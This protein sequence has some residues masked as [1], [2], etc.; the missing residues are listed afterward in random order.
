MKSSPEL[1]TPPMPTLTQLTS[2]EKSIETTYPA[3]PL[4]SGIFFHN[5]FARASRAHIVQLTLEADGEFDVTAFRESLAQVAR[6]HEALRT[7]FVHLANKGLRQIVHR[8]KTP[9]L[10][11]TDL[12]E[13]NDPAASWSQIVEEEYA[14]EF[15]LKNG[16]LFRV[17]LGRVGP[18]ARR[19]VFTWHHIVLDGWS[20][21]L[22]LNEIFVWYRSIQTKTPVRLGKPWSQ[23]AYMRWLGSQDVEAV[24]AYWQKYLSG[25]IKNEDL[26]WARPPSADYVARHH[27]V[28]LDAELSRKI[29]TLAVDWRV[30]PGTLFQVAWALTLQ[31]YQGSRDVLFGHVISGR[32]GNWP[33]IEQAIGLFINTIPVRFQADDRMTVLQ[34]LQR[35]QAETLE[36]ERMGILGLSAIQDASGLGR[37]M[38]NHLF[39]Y[40]NYPVERSTERIAA[41]NRDQLALSTTGGREQTSYHLDVIVLPGAQFTIKLVH[42]T[43]VVES[44]L[45]ARIGVHYE[46]MLREMLAGPNRA[47]GTL[48]FLD[49]ADRRLV[50]V[51]F[52]ATATKYPSEQRIHELFEAQARTKGEATAVVCGNRSLSFAE[53]NAKA[54]Q[55]ARV[56]QR[57]GVRREDVVG[58]V[59]ERS[60]EMSIAL[61]AI[62][63]AGAA[64]LPIDPEYPV[65]RIHYMLTDSGA[66]VVLTQAAQAGKLPASATVL[67]ADDPTLYAGLNTNLGLGGSPRDLLYL[68]YTSGSTGKPKGTAVE[69]GGVV[70]HLWWIKDELSIGPEDRI[71]QKTT[72][73]FDLSVWE[74]FLGAVCGA[75]LHYLAPGAEKDPTAIAATMANERITTAVFV[76][77]ALSLFFQAFADRAKLPEWK[78]CLCCGEPLTSG[79][80]AEFFRK[81][82]KSVR[83]FNLYGPTEA[84]IAV[85]NIEIRADDREI[86]IGRPVANSAMYVLNERLQPVGVGF[87]G[88]LWIGGVQLARGYL[89]RPELTAEKFMADPNGDGARLYRTGDYARWRA[90]GTLDFLG[91]MDDQVKIAGHRIELTEVETALREHRG[92][93]AAAVAA[94]EIDGRKALCAYYVRRPQDGVRLLKR[95]LEFSLF[96]FSGDGSQA[97]ADKYRLVLEGAKIADEAGF[98]AVWT[99]ERHFH[100]FGGLF[101]NAAVMSAALATATRRIGIRAGSVVLP[102]HDPV[103]AA[104]D[105]SVVDNLSGGRVGIAVA[106]GWHANDFVL[107][108]GN[109]ATRRQ[110]LR[111]S[112]RQVQQLWSGGRVTKTNGDGRPVEVAILP[113]PIQP[114][115]P[116]WITA[117]GEDETFRFAGEI[118]ASILTHLL[119][120]GWEELARKIE[121]YRAAWRAG[122]GG[123]GRGGNGHVTLMLHTFVGENVEQVRQTVRDPFRNYLRSSVG[124][125]ADFGRSVG[126]DV[127]AAQKE[128]PKMEVLLDHAFE[129]YFNDA[130]LMG[131]PQSCRR[132]L[133]RLQEIAVDEVA[134]LIDFGVATDESLRSIRA[135]ATMKDAVAAEIAVSTEVAGPRTGAVEE[136]VNP[137]NLRAHLLQRLPSYMLPAYWLELDALPFTSNGKLNRK[138]L[139]QIKTETLAGPYIAPRNDLETKIAAEFSAAVGVERFGV[140]HD[141]FAAGGDSIK[142]IRLVGG[143]RKAGLSV[144]LA[145]L[146]TQSTP[147]TLA[148]HIAQRTQA[149]YVAIQAAE[150]REI[151]PVTSAQKRIFILQQLE[152]G[153]LYNVPGAYRIN[154]ALDPARVEQAIREVILRHA[155]LRTSFE[156]VDDEVVQRVHATAEFAIEQRSDAETTPAELMRGFVQRFDLGRAPL[157]RVLLVQRG[158]G[159]HLLCIDRHHIISDDVSSA[160][161]IRDFVQAYEGRAL[162]ALPLQYPDYA[163]WE[164]DHVAGPERA[165]EEA[166]WLN[167]FKGELPTLALPT[168]FP[169]PAVRSFE[170][171]RLEFL[172]DPALGE[173]LRRLC[174]EQGITPNMLFLAAYAVMLGRY[175]GQE[176][177]VIGMP[178]VGRERAELAEVMGIFVNT[179]SLRL[180]PQARQSFPTFLAGV[181]E[182]V[183][184]AL[185]HQTYPFEALVEALRLPRDTSQNPLFSTMFVY[186]AKETAAA[187]SGLAIEPVR[188]ASNVAKF[189]L[190][191]NVVATSAGFA[192]NFEYA[193]SL[194]AP[195]TIERMGGNFVHL[196]SE[197]VRDSARRLSAFEVCSPA[198]QAVLSAAGR[199]NAPVPAPLPT[200]ISSFAT[201]VVDRPEATALVC[202]GAS[203]TYAE[204]NARAERLARRLASA[205]AVKE[206]V[207]AIAL[208]R[209]IEMIVALVA[210]V[211]T[212]A[213]YL[214]LDS[215]YPAERLAYLLEDSRTQLVVTTPAVAERLPATVARIILD[216]ST[217]ADGLRA[218]P[219]SSSPWFNGPDPENAAYLLYTSGSTGKPKGVVVAHRGIPAMIAA[220]QTNFQVTSES[221]VLQ[222]AS[223]C[224][225]VATA[226][227]CTAL[228]SGATLVVAT[229]ENRGGEALSA[230]IARERVTH[231]MIPPALLTDMLRFPL[232]PL[233]HLITGGEACAPETVARW[234]RATRML[235]VYGVT[236]VT[237]ASLMTEPR[238]D[239]STTDIGRPISQTDAYVLD[240]NL[241]PLPIGVPGEL[242]LGGVQLAR[243]Y[244]NRPDLT[245]ERFIANPFKAG[246]R[247]YRTGDLVKRRED[248]RFDFVGRVDF[249]LKIHGHRIEPA[250]V[251]AAIREQGSI[252]SVV[253]VKRDEQL[254]AY[255]V[256]ESEVN[257]QALRRQLET[258]LPRFMVPTVLQRIDAIP[259]NRNGKIDLARLPAPAV[260]TAAAA[261]PQN[262]TEEVVARILRNALDGKELGREDD[263]FVAG[264]H[265]L[266]AM[267]VVAALRREL[268]VSLE[269]RA[270]FEHPTVAALAGLVAASRTVAPLEISPLPPQAS[271]AVSSQQRRMFIWQ[272]VNRGVVYNL[273]NLYPLGQTCDIARVKRA[274]TEVVARHE[275]LR[276]SFHWGAEKEIVQTIH[277]PGELALEVQEL[278]TADPA[279]AFRAFITPFDLSAGSM[280]HAK[281]LHTAAGEWFLCTDVH[282][283]VA[284]AASMRI[285]LRDFQRAYR[286]EVLPSLRVHY[287]DYV[288]WLDRRLSG[289]YGRRQEAYWTQQFSEPAPTLLLPTDHARPTLQSYEGDRV[290][291]RLEEE[292]SDQLRALGSR[293][294][295]TPFVLFLAVFKVLLHKYSGQEDI[296]VGT[297]VMS[298]DRPELEEIV[299]MF[300]NAVPLRSQPSVEKRFEA[301]LREVKEISVGALE[302]N[303]YPFEQ[304]VQRFEPKRD[305]SRSPLFNTLFLLTQEADAGQGNAP[306]L[307][308]TEV[309]HAKFDLT[310]RITAPPSGPVT[311]VV[312]YG[313]RIFNSDTIWRL[314]RDYEALA[315]QVVAEPAR[316]IGAMSAIDETEAQE[317]VENF[318]HA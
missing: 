58:V 260:A 157:L 57:H 186:V 258:R 168:D 281:V 20:V 253:V 14:H 147:A 90:D 247:L 126:I 105:W 317:L 79:H 41:E 261:A 122:P 277:A 318:S 282:H 288:A 179:L 283:I 95:P 142:A 76:P 156:V 194:F 16:E 249:Q 88:E 11:L 183:L 127:S 180:R 280:L 34:A 97:G 93:T 56:L 205:G 209:S 135:L 152:G 235:N 114:Q 294:E 251:E 112:L 300:L 287:K 293:A 262:P 115:L 52:N 113:R 146:F 71:L 69:H 141:F 65:D 279:A 109:Y 32:S 125:L 67:R 136:A 299:G 21:P 185:A 291:L 15:D 296:V 311:V 26:P 268:G 199:P 275:A 244:L 39:R 218:G 18:R 128:S 33:G 181:K 227:I 50:Q 290:E 223:F 51:E 31:R 153:S 237:V 276:T 118:G 123:E 226:E 172:L 40:E 36:S 246:D 263:F 250:E 149:Q 144:E 301:Y 64:Y 202:D 200:F 239:R 292:L 204:L 84:T 53:L 62:A 130:T 87:I 89:K 307:P 55:L 133:R 224:F 12:R 42:N 284:D 59:L 139:P 164:Q 17:R 229:S 91:R 286:G 269:L 267:Q 2:S 111:E 256:A 162:E 104:E 100:A 182:T 215:D 137:A 166:Y 231:A 82:P 197:M 217:E 8:E 221:R 134:C 9:E 108:P 19:I 25:Y 305:L 158:A 266:R 219:A 225:D 259:L 240:A 303:S 35:H 265:S 54:N 178:V 131:T 117:A 272:Q 274:L 184:S 47:I 143:L 222:L 212:G 198:E 73:T 94:R 304:L 24:K 85:T 86:T 116:L 201:Q 190:T 174:S 154:G 176:D 193:T 80:Q 167:Q 96:Y 207:V 243:G 161:L 1:T 148:R 295:V 312:E 66:Q 140:E 298:R 189:D 191:L 37:G 248:G 124:L 170:G 4:Q 310:M 252:T 101:P 61:L 271:Y 309:V 234:S 314:V 233:T 255:F 188:F 270:I 232:P 241:L 78:R 103:R 68:M 102:L 203:L 208:P 60:V 13:E 278:S 160:I 245:A 3:T 72:Y 132:T 81:A 77:S 236:E 10:R 38:I 306:A 216:G 99:P 98:T 302:F 285:M 196:L 48:D 165:R 210:V 150:A 242:F 5:E 230:L 155:A 192:V 228:A 75:S 46:R 308:G 173:R 220:H 315:R 214:P 289:D 6:R 171:A 22:L 177:L 27:T 7:N 213:A 145:D 206:R 29:Q 138:A 313:A 92:L 83:L 110:V 121:I 107:S 297:S 163:V 119:G 30:T 120:Q 187:A 70:N 175:A 211:K 159:E 264:G 63:K 129:R 151:Y 23:A 45:V 74:L 273:P 238:G 28:E 254:C 43:R 106:S 44:D 257:L 169:R 49:D 316:R 195:A